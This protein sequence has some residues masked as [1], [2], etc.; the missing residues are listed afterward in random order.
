MY[1]NCMSSSVPWGPLHSKTCC[2]HNTPKDSSITKGPDSA[3]LSWEIESF[4]LL[5]PSMESKLMAK[6]QGPFKVTR[7]AGP[8]DY[9]V[10]LPGRQSETRIN[11]INLLKAWKA[12]EGLLIIAFP[13]EPKLKPLVDGPLESGPAMMGS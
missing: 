2:R 8:I 1:C 13:T 12:S 6:W 5:L 10:Q 11:H 7:W 3:I 4:L 9:E